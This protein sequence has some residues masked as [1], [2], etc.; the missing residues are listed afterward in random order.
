MDD[1]LVVPRFFSSIHLTGLQYSS[2]EQGWHYP[3]HRH[4]IFEIMYCERGQLTETINGRAYSLPAGTAILI[5]SGV[6]HS[7][8]AEEDSVYFNFHF[9]MDHQEIRMTLQGI[10]DP[11]LTPDDNPAESNQLRIWMEH[12]IDHFVETYRKSERQESFSEQQML[13][14]H[15]LKTIQL[16]STWLKFV[17]Y[18][19]ESQLQKTMI[20][21]SMQQSKLQIA[22]EVA[23]LLENDK[24]YSMHISELSSKLNVHRTYICNCFREVYGVSPKYYAQQL[25]IKKAKE[26]LQLTDLPVS[27]IAQLLSFSSTEYFCRFFR[28]HVG[29]TPYKYRTSPSHA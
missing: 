14:G 5:K 17:T 18:L 12:F 10:E 6:L 27:G 11:I 25:R 1:N 28:N 3:V 20:R 22:N 4:P 26:L 23:Y 19:V 2:V 13:L 21:S 29:F 24:T 7:V 15:S 16:Q 8:K 9:S